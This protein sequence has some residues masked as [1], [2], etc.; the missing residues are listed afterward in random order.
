MVRLFPDFA[1][2]DSPIHEQLIRHCSSVIKYSRIRYHM[3]PEDLA[4]EC[5]LKWVENPPRY[6]PARGTMST[7]LGVT[8]RSVA[9]DISRSLPNKRNKEQYLEYLEQRMKIDEARCPYED[10]LVMDM[11]NCSLQGEMNDCIQ[12]LI[13]GW[14]LVDLSAV[15]GVPWQTI[16]YRVKL[17]LDDI[18]RKNYYEVVETET[19]GE[20]E[21]FP[22]STP[23][24][25]KGD[26]GFS[27]TPREPTC[28][29]S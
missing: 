26:R 28:S 3:G 27:L 14:K 2:P 23:V 5:Y 9:L 4:Q 22:L 24:V 19:F 18:R 20:V 29:L 15:Y 17:S 16:Q 11:I 12:K 6:N 10:I 21:P 7:F 13:D 1:D 8:V 25:R